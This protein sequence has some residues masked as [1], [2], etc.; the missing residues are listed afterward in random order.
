MP[1]LNKKKNPEEEKPEPP[2][3]AS[4]E[5]DQGKKVNAKSDQNSENTEKKVPVWFHL[6]SGLTRDD[7][8]TSL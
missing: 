4:D 3:K 5:D 7:V 8:G 6:L 1:C 2:V